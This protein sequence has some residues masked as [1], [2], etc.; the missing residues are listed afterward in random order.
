MVTFSL[1]LARIM[2]P[3]SEVPCSS[4]SALVA[5]NARADE[6]G[7]DDQEVRGKSEGDSEGGG[8]AAHD[9]KDVYWIVFKSCWNCW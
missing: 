4:S 6:A 3:I 8:L 2:Q 7:D 1:F 5:E 9:V